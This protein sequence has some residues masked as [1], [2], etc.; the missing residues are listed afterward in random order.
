MSKK[1][2]KI[3]SE[4]AP[5][6]KTFLGGFIKGT[7]WA[8]LMLVLLA[9]VFYKAGGLELLP[10]IQ[11]EIAQALPR[12]SAPKT[13][14]EA[15]HITIDLSQ[16]EQSD[17][18]LPEVMPVNDGPTPLGPKLEE[19]EVLQQLAT[20]EQADTEVM[21]ELSAL[22][23]HL[24]TLQLELITQL[25]QQ[26]ATPVEVTLPEIEA[27]ELDISF[28][29][30]LSGLIQAA[31]NGKSIIPYVQAMK[32]TVPDVYA[33]ALN[34]LESVG[35]EPLV[36]YNELLSSAYN[37][38]FKKH[39]EK[40]SDTWWSRFIKIEK[41]DEK[42]TSEK[43]RTQQNRDDLMQALISQNFEK[44]AEL[45]AGDLKHR[46]QLYIAQQ[47]ALNTFLAALTE[48]DAS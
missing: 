16:I 17:E 11:Q 44:A 9:G 24:N 33:P 15:T 45:A 20:A 22:K 21:K 25:Q 48:G 8:G 34:A 40:Q 2:A 12:F 6:P 18:G 28:I 7:L 38:N 26:A 37:L 36:T 27:P 42:G 4:P 47:N 14:E 5:K 3:K 10:R 43:D 13:P 30:N 32:T 29:Q 31:Y 35:G 1:T 46:I 39:I 41:L 19:L 23:Q